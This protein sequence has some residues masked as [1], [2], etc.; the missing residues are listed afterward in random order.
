M[1]NLQAL[2]R[3]IASTCTSP[4]EV[5]AKL[6]YHLH[7]VTDSSRF[8]TF[9]YADWNPASRSLRY[10]NAGHNPPIVLGTLSGLALDK[11]GIPLGILPQYP[12]ETG[13]AVL[14]PGDLMVLYSD[15]ITE[16]GLR[17]DREFGE[18][19]LRALVSEFRYRPLTE[20]QDRLIATVRAW[21]GQE[22][23][24]DMTVVIVR[25]TSEAHSADA[26]AKETL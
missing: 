6:N 16:A 18:D 26:A 3:V 10:V 12:Y 25:A 19:R 7:Q 23:E 1:A 11:G 4:G 9:F 14:C 22:A 2:L 17:E 13:E 24:D 21:S 5:C 15:G 20:L 8:A